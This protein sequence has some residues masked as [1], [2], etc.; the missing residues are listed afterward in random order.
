MVFIGGRVSD[1]L[2]FKA[3][4]SALIE[5]QMWDADGDTP[6]R[7]SVGLLGFFKLSSFCVDKSH[8][9]YAFKASL[10]C[11]RLVFFPPQRYFGSVVVKNPNKPPCSLPYVP[12]LLLLQFCFF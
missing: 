7:A 9:G 6:V 11:L 1:Q 5:D 4:D 10:R 3:G 2:G 8:P 12:S